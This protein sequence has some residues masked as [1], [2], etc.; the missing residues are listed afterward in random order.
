MAGA[1]VAELAAALGAVSKH[2][3]H[4]VA[5]VKR[6]RQLARESEQRM[7]RAGLRRIAF[8]LRDVVGDLGKCGQIVL[9]QQTAVADTT[10]R[11]NAVPDGATAERVI[12]ALEPAV[13]SLREVPS[14]LGTATTSLRRLQETVADILRG[15]KPERL[16]GLLS[17]VETRL[18]QAS[19][20]ATEATARAETVLAS[21]RAAGRLDVPGIGGLRPTS[22]DPPAKQRRERPAWLQRTDL[23]HQ[24]NLDD[25]PNYELNEIRLTTGKRMDSYVHGE[26]IVERK[27]TQLAEVEEATAIGYLRSTYSKYKEGNYIDSTP[28]NRELSP[29]L[30]GKM[31]EGDLVLKV[32]VQKAPVPDRVIEAAIELEIEIR[33]TEG[34]SYP[35]ED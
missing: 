22:S 28:R 8:R 19:G 3:D 27:Y 10:A 16:I 11:V 23:G 14:H 15:S 12:T 20:A 32:P 17:D 24:F 7:G 30:V 1:D 4:A 31:T 29:E 2:L 26:E 34:R 33:D 25:H 21:A 35:V 9:A 6:A 5:G 18:R 13:A